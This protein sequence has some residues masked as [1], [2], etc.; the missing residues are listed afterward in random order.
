MLPL[1]WKDATTSFASTPSLHVPH[2]DDDD[3]DDENDE[4]IYIIRFP[5]SLLITLM[6]AKTEA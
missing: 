2:E 1:P 3:E 4:E 6:C 5:Y